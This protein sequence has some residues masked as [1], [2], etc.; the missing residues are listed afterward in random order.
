[1]ANMQRELKIIRL[2]EGFEL[3]VFELPYYNCVRNL[4]L[5]GAELVLF[6]DRTVQGRNS[7]TF[8]TGG[9]YQAIFSDPQIIRP[10]FSKTPNNQFSFC[11]AKLD[12]KEIT[13]A[14]ST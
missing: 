12:I 7:W 6:Q 10:T 3:K 13:M 14:Y 8:G 9:S 2:T 5:D 11:K 1:M 4:D